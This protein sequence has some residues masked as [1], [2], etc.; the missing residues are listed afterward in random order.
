M[1]F[2]V[3]FVPDPA[4]EPYK[5]KPHSPK[6]VKFKFRVDFTNGGHVE[7]EDFLLDVEGEDPSPERLAEMIVSAMNLLR[8]GPVTIYRMEIVNRGAHYDG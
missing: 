2:P 3:T 4:A 1:I 8:A 7:G 5:A 6:R